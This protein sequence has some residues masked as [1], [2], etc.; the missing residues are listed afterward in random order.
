[1]INVRLL[2]QSTVEVTREGKVIVKGVGQVELPAVVGDITVR[3]DANTITV[4]SG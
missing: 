1:M 2:S 4:V 3:R